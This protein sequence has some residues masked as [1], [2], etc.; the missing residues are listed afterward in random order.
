MNTLARRITGIGPL[1]SV[2]RSNEFLKSDLLEG[3]REM[4]VKAQEALKSI[5]EPKTGERMLFVTDLW[6]PESPSSA[7]PYWNKRIGIARIWH[8]AAIMLA[9]Q[10]GFDL[11]PVLSFPY[12]NHGYFP[13]KGF[14]GDNAADAESAVM[15]ADMLIC[16]PGFSFSFMHDMLKSP[17]IPAEKKPRALFLETSSQGSLGACLESIEGMKGKAN[18]LE[19][20]LAGAV[21]IEVTFHCPDKKKFGLY[22]DIRGSSW[23]KDWEF[24]VERNRYGNALPVGEYCTAPN[25]GNG[26]PGSSLTQGFWPV[27]D[28]DGYRY[29]LLEV[30]NNRI[31]KVAGDSPIASDIRIYM[32]HLGCNNDNVAEIAWGINGEARKGEIAPDLNGADKDHAGESERAGKGFLRRL[33]Q[34]SRQ[35]QWKETGAKLG[36]CEKAE[37]MHIAFGGNQHFMDAAHPHRVEGKHHQDVVYNDMTPITVSARVVF[38]DSHREL[39]MDSGKHALF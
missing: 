6:T 20:A 26:S 11:Q 21:G 23:L 39:I 22:V 13:K 7:N 28:K 5:F 19:K 4:V 14:L 29:A 27:Y 12:A 8:E 37:G 1:L 10:E 32:G 38:P 35:P 31:I 9:A 2:Q 34:R 24:S 25:P 17:G 16:M 33:P 36:E 15:A 3:H 30:K 18:R